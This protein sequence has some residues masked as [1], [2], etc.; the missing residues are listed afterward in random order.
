M[1]RES[2][3]TLNSTYSGY[4]NFVTPIQI[5][6][7]FSCLGMNLWFERKSWKKM[8]IEGF[9]CVKATIQVQS[10]CRYPYGKY[11]SGRVPTL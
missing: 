5:F 11:T 8:G 4:A 2:L 3:P 6:C 7:E 10:N 1:A 9:V